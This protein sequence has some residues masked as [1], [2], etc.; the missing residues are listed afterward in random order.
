VADD[1]RHSAAEQQD[2]GPGE[3]ITTYADM[4]TLLLTFFVMLVA[5]SSVNVE[6]FE[7]IMKSIQF[8]LGASVAPGGKMGRI[9]THD[10]RSKSL[11]RPTGAE[12][13][14]LLQDIQESI[15]QK[16]LKDSVQVVQQGNKVIVRVKGKVLFPSASAKF[17]PQAKKVLAELAKIVMQHPDYR[18]DVG[19]HTDPRPIS[20]PKY[21]SNWELSALRATRV[22]RY[23]VDQG[24]NPRRM[25]ATGYADTDPIAPNT[26]LENM[27]KNRRVEFV[28]EKKER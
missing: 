18:L 8:T 1:R 9:D 19:G 22:L 25:T 4:V 23:L 26:S 21:D 7:K 17:D 5:I 24:V 3:W 2:D 28:L 16:D 20:T 14:P 11:S 13:E 6:Q 27:A 15:N 12:N 10:V